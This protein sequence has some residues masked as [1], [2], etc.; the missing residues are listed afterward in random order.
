MRISLV[1]LITLVLVVA[2]TAYIYQ[3]QLANTTA[4]LLLLLSSI[5][6]YAVIIWLIKRYSG[7]RFGAML[8]N[9][10]QPIDVKEILD[11][12][13]Y[14]RSVIVSSEGKLF[15]RVAVAE[16]GIFMYKAGCYSLLLRWKDVFLEPAD[17]KGFSKITLKENPQFQFYIPWPPEFE[18]QYGRF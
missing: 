18:Q 11:I 8:L 1:R 2:G 14:V 17:T 10:S 12:S 7:K 6:I 3:T 9:F 16:P 4:V 15:S 13:P 5:A